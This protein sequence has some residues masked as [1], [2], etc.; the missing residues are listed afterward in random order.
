M[1]KSR[2]ED[3]QKAVETI[4]NALGHRIQRLREEYQMKEMRREEPEG[5]ARGLGLALHELNDMLP[6]RTRFKEHA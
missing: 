2:N 6:R 5:V 1:A 4:L 3:E